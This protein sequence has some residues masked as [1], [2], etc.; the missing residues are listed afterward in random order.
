MTINELKTDEAEVKEKIDISVQFLK[1]KTL[2]FSMLFY[3]AGLIFGAFLY[4]KFKGD[5]LN[6]LILAGNSDIFLQ[7]LINDLSRY[8]LIFAITVL[9]G[10]CLIGFP[11]I[12]VIPML[13]GFETAVK[14][15]YYY[16]GYG[17]HGFGY[18]LLMIA[19][20]SCLLLTIVMLAINKSYALSK[21]IYNLTV[22]KTEC[23]EIN[24]KSY[25]ISYLIYGVLLLISALADATAT[26]ALGG[27]IKL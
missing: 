24:Y 1:N 17:M 23:D 21:Q 14:I 22:K 4:A 19:P 20:F 27:I 26:T 25:L 9:L 16:C 13:I 11:V 12:N 6:S 7:Q 10:I 5:A 3:T 18:S 2:I 15:T 8:Y